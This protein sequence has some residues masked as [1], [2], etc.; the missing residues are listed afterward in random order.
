MADTLGEGTGRG[1][2]AGPGPPRF[3][4]IVHPLGFF[5]RVLWQGIRISPEFFFF[6]LEGKR[7]EYIVHSLGP[8]SLDVTCKR[9]F[10]LLGRG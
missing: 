8:P 1:G 4:I 10:L 5:T 7:I 3:N 2:G 6:I 9:F